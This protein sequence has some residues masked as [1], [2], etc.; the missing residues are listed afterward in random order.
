MRELR[1]DF[2]YL[3]D[4]EQLVYSEKDSTYKK[5]SL[6]KERALVIKNF[7]NRHLTIAAAGGCLHA[8]A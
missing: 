1:A 5:P 4:V 7:Q 8:P 3:Q 2:I 6:I